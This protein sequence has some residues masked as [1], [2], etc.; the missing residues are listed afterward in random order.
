MGNSKCFRKGNGKRCPY[1]NPEKPEKCDYYKLW[2]KDI[3][4]SEGGG[5]PPH[6]A[7]GD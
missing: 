2:V 4:V 7:L 6:E 3:R 1:N 5:I